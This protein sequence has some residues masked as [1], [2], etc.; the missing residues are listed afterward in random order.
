MIYY[1]T[2]LTGDTRSWVFWVVTS[3]A[4]VF[5]LVGGYLMMKMERVGCALMS[6]WAG[7]NIGLLL[8]ESLLYI[9]M[10]TT[11]FWTTTWAFAFVGFVL[12][13][14]WLN[15]GLIVS[16]SINGSFLVMKGFGTMLPGFPNNR[17]LID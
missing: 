2:F 11:V 15:Y 1:M 6:A 12:G 9:Y 3:F 14:T 16:T 13:F 5:G 10:S 7:F 17:V 8:N 4:L